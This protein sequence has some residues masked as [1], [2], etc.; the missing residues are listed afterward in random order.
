[1]QGVD[2]PAGGVAVERPP[3]RE[4]ADEH[5][6]GKRPASPRK[7]ADALA[8][9]AGAAGISIAAAFMLLNLRKADF[10]VP[11][12]Y[13]G[14]A[15]AYA[16]AVKSTL[17]HGWWWTNPSV[18]APGSL[19]LYDFPFA[20]HDTVHLLL[21]K[22]MS[23]FSSDWALLFNLYFLLGF[24]LIT[25]TSMAVLRHFR[26]GYGPAIVA[27]VLYSFLPSRLLKG[28]GNLFLDVFFEVPLAILVLL[29]VCSDEPPLFR[30]RVGSRWPRI[31]LR[32]ARSWGS[33]VIC[34]LLA[35]TS[36]YYAAFA[37]FLLVAGGIWSSAQRHSIRN[38]L[39]G[40]ALTCA[41]LVGLAG[42]VLPSVA[43]HARHG[44]NALA[45]RVAY[46]AEI[47][48]LRITQLLVPADGHRLQAFLDLKR[49][50]NRAP[51]A[52]EGHS[53]SLGL[54]GSAGFILLLG[55]ALSGRH[56]ARPE[57]HVLR[58]LAVLNLMA[59]LLGTVGGLG[60]LFALLVHPQVRGYLRISVYIGFFALFAVALVLQRL[61][62]RLPVLGRFAFPV[63]LGLG[64]LD[65]STWYAVPAYASTKKEYASDAGLVRRVEA[66][67]PA[68]AMVFE[69]P[70]MRFPEMPSIQN[71]DTYDP[72]RPYLHSHTLRW[73]FP[74]MRNR[75]GDRLAQDLTN[76]GP[77]RT[78]RSLA[79]LGFGGVLVDRD[80]YADRGAGIEAA[81]HDELG[82]APLVSED[83]R[84]TFF[85]V[86]DYARRRHASMS[87][88][89]LASDREIAAHPLSILWDG[90]CYGVEYNETKKP[91]RWCRKTGEL[92]IRNDASFQRK[93]SIHMKF[94]AARAPARLRLDGL[95]SGQLDL[96]GAAP[97]D[98][99]IDVP[100]GEYIVRFD[101][102]GRPADA[103]G[104]PRTMVWRVA[105]FSMEEIR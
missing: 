34:A 47:Y 55:V 28:E 77:G 54:V 97:L 57:E 17:D 46:E 68:G 13:R 100:P 102:D 19:D 16:L 92:R 72:I 61:E 87:P 7:T 69:L 70:Y 98:R 67:L 85:D 94:Y 80:G 53:T 63:V 78:L 91:F 4:P 38:A 71:M 23:A 99:E 86:T 76:G 74:T 64:L 50:Y 65:Q 20:A 15:L 33:L 9:Y 62:R 52:D 6:L 59:I 36:F 11:F 37:G 93:A 95:L 103:P 29:W 31:E 96:T 27:S 22:A 84:L 79:D 101:C 75:E 40:A 83:G 24:P 5:S 32:R 60:S 82:V 105:D 8:A 25:L 90:G 41:I 3:R 39:S 89:E 12:A 42:G 88:E 66:A 18:G 49:R 1:M 44:P 73:S 58:P 104:D 81:F 56:S 21:I 10:H 26:V 43:Y 2:Q 35:T 48:G 14:D 30:D 45:E 51:Q